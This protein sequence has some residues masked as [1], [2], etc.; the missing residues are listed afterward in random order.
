MASHSAPHWG[1]LVATL[2]SLL[3]GHLQHGSLLPQHTQGK[4]RNHQQEGSHDPL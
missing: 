2:S 1:W 3:G 4:K